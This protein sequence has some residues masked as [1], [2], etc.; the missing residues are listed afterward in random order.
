VGRTA[1]APV[2]PATVRW[3]REVA[4]FSQE[5]IA[6]KLRV[7]A[8]RIETWETGE[9]KPTLAQLKKLAYQYRRPPAF[10]FVP[11][12]PPPDLPQPPDFRSASSRTDYSVS[13]RRGLRAAEEQRRT[14]LELAEPPTSSLVALNVRRDEP[15]AAAAGVRSSIGVSLESQFA[16]PSPARALRL[17]IS[18]AEALGV[19]VFQ[20]SD[21]D[22]SEAR[23]VSLDHTVAPI[24][25][26]NGKDAAAGKSFTLFHELFHL[27]RSTSGL[28][29]LEEQVSV[30]RQCNVFAAHVLMPRQAV[31]DQ[32]GDGDPRGEV[33]RLARRFSVSSDAMAIRLSELGAL[34]QADVEAIREETAERV[35]GQEPSGFLP[36]HRRRFRDLGARYVSAVLE[37]YYEERLTLADALQYL[38]VKV[39]DLRRIE[40]DIREQSAD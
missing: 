23:G 6:R 9:E 28:C 32:L 35:S 3:A 40:R 15:A 17:W 16:A 37:S 8:D 7:T 10:F 4:G 39:P 2:S 1:A 25:V 22:L 21:V 27:L 11:D 20:M 31:L 12:P 5:E 30:E 24:I 29:Q 26:I 34:A 38:R 33:S 13:L 18:A 36:Y 19:L 14:L